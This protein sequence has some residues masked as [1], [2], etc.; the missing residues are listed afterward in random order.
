MRVVGLCW[1]SLDGEE[2]VGNQEYFEDQQ[3]Q[4]EFVNQGKCSMGLPWCHIH[5]II[6]SLCMCLIL[7]DYKDIL[8]IDDVYL[9]PYE[10]LLHMGRM[11][12]L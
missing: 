10:F 1:S 4:Q 3:D 8:V 2:Y 6:Y 12:V 7:L 11:L 9:D 5:Y